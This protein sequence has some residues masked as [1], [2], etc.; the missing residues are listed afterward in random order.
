MTLV[1]E[2]DLGLDGLAGDHGRPGMR[3][4]TLFQFEHLVP[5]ASFMGRAS[6][7]PIDLRRNILVESLNLSAL[8]GVTLQLGE[9]TVEITT[10]CAPCSRMAETFGPGGYN[11][12]R[13]HG[14]WCAKVLAEG[15]VRL[16]DVV[17]RSDLIRSN[18]G[19]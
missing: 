10:P 3:A 1:T 19:V 12:L 7:D 13:G 11:A 9:A 8:R 2:A 4:V 17:K 16:G 15:R 6:I 5:V 14:G 18:F